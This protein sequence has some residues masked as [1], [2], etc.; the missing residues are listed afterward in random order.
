MAQKPSVWYLTVRKGPKVGSAYPLPVGAITIGRHADNQIVID[1][2]MVSRHHTRLT[3]Q[4][5]SFLLEDLGSANGT[6]VNN[7][8][9]SGPALLRN[10]DIVGLSQEV[11]LAFSDQPHA[12]A[13]MYDSSARREPVPVAAPLPSVPVAV[14][15]SPPAAPPARANQG[16]LAFSMGGVIA[17]IAIAALVVVGAAIYLLSEKPSSQA[18]LPTSTPT[19]TPSPTVVPTYTPYPTYTTV[20]TDVPT[21]TPYPT[22][23]PVPTD[24]PTATP[25]PTYTPVPTDVP[26]ATPYPTYTLFP[27][28]TPRPQPVQQPT[29]TPV[30]TPTS[31]PAP[32]TVTLGRNVSYEPWG[33]PTDPGGCRGPYNDE[34]PVRR[35]TV[36]IILT[37]NSNQFIPDWWTPTFVSAKGRPLPTCIWYYNNTVVQP[38]ETINVT[39]ATHLEA[40]DWVAALVFDELNY[41]LSICL[42]GGGQQ[43]PCQ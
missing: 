37:N 31:S 21:A 27:T 26:T 34:S 5:N 13:T 38:D 15:A 30:P 17:L 28:A 32:F 25:Y 19:S 40:D 10:G 7:V 39:F 18:N 3:W 36:E 16:C 4:G 33:R 2:P 9:I 41:T 12:D 24:V 8:R 20:P 11:L 6:W 42:N 1:D 35:F 29:Q 22:Y 14:S 23:T 43:V